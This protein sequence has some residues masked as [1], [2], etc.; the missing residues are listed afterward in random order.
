[1]PNGQHNVHDYLFRDPFISYQFRSIIIQLVKIPVEQG[2][3]SIFIA[4]T[5]K[6]YQM[7]IS[8]GSIHIKWFTIVLLRGVLTESGN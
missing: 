1:L 6:R 3:V 2:T 8:C 5:P 4:R 7:A